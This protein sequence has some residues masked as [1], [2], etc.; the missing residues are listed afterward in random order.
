[1][2]YLFRMNDQH[3]NFAP[4]FFVVGAAKAGTTAVYHWLGSHPDVF[5][6]PVK[7]PGYFAYAGGQATPSSGPYD[8]DY[9]RQIVSDEK[10]YAALYDKAGHLLT[11]DIS[12]VYLLDKQAAQRIAAIRPDSRIIVLL[13]D[14]V[15]RAF[16]QFMHHVRD[17]LE[18]CETFEDALLQEEKRLAA[19]WSW[20]HGYATH[21]FY[22]AQIERYLEVFP[23][24]QFLFI[25]YQD[26]QTDPDGC[27]RKICGHLGI[28]PSALVKNERV[29][30]TENLKTVSSRPKLTHCLRHPGVIQRRLKKVMPAGFRARLR[31]LLEG[32]ERPVPVLSPDTKRALAIRYLPERTRIEAL[33]GLNLEGWFAPSQSAP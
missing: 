5:L 33:S 16:S 2:C 3:A 27:W 21:G 26:L 28:E 11:G 22:A 25:E 7:E 13:R 18:T 23:R 8:P 32:S 17:G 31:K 1:M 9:T 6:P 15:H 10:S 12:P 20:G 24:A 4:D 30:A 29:N 14:P 19:G